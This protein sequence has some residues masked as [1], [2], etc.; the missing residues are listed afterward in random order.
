[1]SWLELLVDFEVD[2]GLRCMQDEPVTP[3]WGVRA[4]LLKH[5]VKIMLIVRGKGPKTMDKHWGCTKRIASLAPFGCLELE[6]LLRRPAFA[7]GVTTTRAVARNAWTW[8]SSK[9]SATLREFHTDYKG[10][11][12]GGNHKSEVINKVMAITT[13]TGFASSGAEHESSI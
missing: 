11:H 13:S 2:S 7:G 1:M 9:S 8:A 6:G 3:S 10:F 5:I 12:V 4:V